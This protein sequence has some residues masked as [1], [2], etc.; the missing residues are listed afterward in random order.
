MLDRFCRDDKA[1]QTGK[2][3]RKCFHSSAWV[4]G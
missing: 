3:D 1:E 2:E 4:V